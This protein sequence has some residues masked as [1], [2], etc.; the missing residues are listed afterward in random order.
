MEKKA[1][2]RIQNT[3][4]SQTVHCPMKK[5]RKELAKIVTIGEKKRRRSR[6]NRAWQSFSVEKNPR[7]SLC[8]RMKKSHKLCVL[9]KP[10]FFD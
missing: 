10:G 6:R 9:I 4:E 7:N 2:N 5:H 3:S 1:F 8:N